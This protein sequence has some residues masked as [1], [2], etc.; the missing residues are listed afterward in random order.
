ML[1]PPSGNW[2]RRARVR[3]YGG[4]EERLT[5][6]DNSLNVV[7]AKALLSRGRQ[8]NCL[9]IKGAVRVIARTRNDIAPPYVPFLRLAAAVPASTILSTS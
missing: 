4:S 6:I 3:G 8:E 5:H 2:S 1:S 9:I 7:P